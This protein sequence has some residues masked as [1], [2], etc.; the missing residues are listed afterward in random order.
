[1]GHFSVAPLMKQ[2]APV[3]N[4][5]ILPQACP[6]DLSESFLHTGI[7]SNLNSNCELN[8]TPGRKTG[9]KT[10]DNETDT[11]KAGKVLKG[12]KFSSTQQYR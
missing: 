1:M 12:V 11:G 3:L 8:M 7:L 5:P 6:L 9:R 10:N 4:P 2:P